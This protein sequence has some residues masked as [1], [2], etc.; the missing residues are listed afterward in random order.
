L[1]PEFFK[2]NA[3]MEERPPAVPVRLRR[4]VAVKPVGSSKLDSNGQKISISRGDAMLASSYT[5]VIGP[6]ESFTFVPPTTTCCQPPV[7][8]C[9]CLEKLDQKLVIG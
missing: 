8:R 5:D 9:A 7:P 1:A 6:E 2:V 4:V 3:N